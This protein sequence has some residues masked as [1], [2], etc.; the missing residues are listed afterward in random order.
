MLPSLS[1]SSLSL[2]ALEDERDEKRRRLEEWGHQK[3][4]LERRMVGLERDLERLDNAIDALEEQEQ[5]E[6]NNNTNCNPNTGNPNN[7]NS[8]NIARI[9]LVKVEPSSSGIPPIM[10]TQSKDKDEFFTDPTTPTQHRQTQPQPQ[11]IAAQNHHEDLPREDGNNKNNDDT[12]HDE[13]EDDHWLALELQAYEESLSM[14]NNYNATT[15]HTICKSANNINNTANNTATQNNN[16]KNNPAAPNN[17]TT[18]TIDQYFGRPTVAA[19]PLQSSLHNTNSLQQQPP[20][21]QQG[22]ILEQLSAPTNGSSS[23]SNNTN[24]IPNTATHRLGPDSVP[25]PYQSNTTTINNAPF[26]SSTPPPPTSSSSSFPWSRKIESLLHDTFRIPS[27]RDQQHAIVNATLAGRDVFVIM[28]T[29]GGKS[30][31]YQLPALYEGRHTPP[32]VPKKITFCISPLL[33]LIQDQEEQMNAFCPGSALSF[34]S[35]HS[36]AEQARRWAR[37]RDD[38]SNRNS[39]C[40]VLITPERVSKSNKLC[41]ELDKLHAQQRLGRFVIDEAHCACQWGHDFRP[42]T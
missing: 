13:N 29:G 9:D 3:R 7:H 17:K 24:I 10:D 18:T 25:K 40:L 14:S 31:T 15:N 30:L 12:M 33:S 2:E 23:S 28:R 35:A 16:P 6:G 20:Q 19:A 27:F 1:S 26:S 39:I 34:S 21:Q 37:V 22:R 11:P 36:A 38:T 4:A 42:G 32:Q 41:A 8:S 5:A